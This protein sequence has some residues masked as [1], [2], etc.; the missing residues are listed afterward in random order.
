MEASL[1]VSVP[2]LGGAVEALQRL[3]MSWEEY[4]RLPEKPKAEFVDGEVVVMAPVGEPHGEATV[5]L[6]AR[7][8]AS[9]PDLRVM[10]EVGLHLPRNRLR[11]PDLMVVERAATGR[12]VTD[13]PVLVVEVLSPSTRAEDTI[14]KSGEYAEGGVG[15][16]WVVDPDLRT[17]DVYANADGAWQ[18]LAHVDAASPTA[19]I[20]VPP[21]GVVPVD[22]PEI[23]GA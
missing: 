1:D 15:Q 11:A 12:W 23:L 22:L 5:R 7:L 3:H 13:A 18:P 14:R 4:L 6:A 19:Y 8:L 16:Y 21:H 2:S 17:I 20:E 10:T 9:L